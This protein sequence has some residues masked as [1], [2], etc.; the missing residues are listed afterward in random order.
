MNTFIRV[1]EVWVPSEDGSLL[2]LRD[3]L[4]DAAPAFGASSRSMCF[5]RAEGL[6]GN[7]WEEGRPLLLSRLE[8]SYFRRTAAARAAGLS[9]ATALP[10]FV[11]ERLTSVVVL[12]CGDQPE[13]E[14]QVGAIE[15]WRNDPR[16]E[17]DLRLAEGYFG[18]TDPDLEALSRDSFLPRGQGLPG[19][20]WQR[21]AAVFIEDIGASR[22][23]LRAQTAARAGIVRGL[24]LPCSTR[25]HQTWVVSLLSAPQW[26]I[27]RRIESWLPNAAGTALQRAFGF[28]EVAGTLAAAD[29]T[30][31][32]VDALGPI[33][34]AWASASAQVAHGQAAQGHPWSAHWPAAALRS[35]LAIPLI[36]DERV[37]E[38]VALYF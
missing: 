28:C 31:T 9:C 18:A 27:A 30:A 7:A 35:V 2:E 13:H 3:G 36:A 16:V 32:P 15:L 19:L 25:T 5:G 12:L 20:A 1:A 24:A 29:A 17:S 33:G 34:L 21:E 23:F 6:P 26:P 4:F 22:H 11:G 10:I 8:G 14:A 38:V 37:S